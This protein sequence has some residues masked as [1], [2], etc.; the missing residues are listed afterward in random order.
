MR[1]AMADQNKEPGIVLTEEQ[2]RRQRSRSIAM[3]IA[4]AALVAMIWAVTLVK[5]VGG[6]H[7]Y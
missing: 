7:R 5:G 1:L 2:K 3:A 4:L 6:L